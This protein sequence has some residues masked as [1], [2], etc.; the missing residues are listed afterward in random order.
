MYIFNNIIFT[1]SEYEVLNTPSLEMESMLDGA[2]QSDNF[3][4][5]LNKLYSRCQFGPLDQ[6]NVKVMSGFA[7]PRPGSPGTFVWVNTSADYQSPDKLT[8]F[9]KKLN[10]KFSDI[11]SG[12]Y[13]IKFEFS[14]VHSHIAV[15]NVLDA[16]VYWLVVEL[17]DI[18]RIFKSILDYNTY[19]STKNAFTLITT[20]PRTFIG[21]ITDKQEPRDVGCNI[22]L[23]PTIKVSELLPT[24]AVKDVTTIAGE[25]RRSKVDINVR[26]WINNGNYF[27]Y[28]DMVCDFNIGFPIR[29]K[30]F[31][32]TKVSFD[33]DKFAKGDWTVPNQNSTN[34]LVDVNVTGPLPDTHSYVSYKGNDNSQFLPDLP[35]VRN[36]VNDVQLSISKTTVQVDESKNT[37]SITLTDDTISDVVYVSNVPI[38]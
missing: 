19:K 25:T 7:Y 10:D 22:T 20:F 30:P 13:T 6:I 26:Q 8:Q 24:G 14:L 32:T 29:F 9:V 4:E 36:I 33:R 3:V 35:P 12:S 37:A 2:L 28:H 18:R 23:P 11:V 17:V 27:Y 31:A 15:P 38:I 21:I 5:V 1:E 16:D 34:N